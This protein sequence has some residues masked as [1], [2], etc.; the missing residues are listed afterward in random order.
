MAKWLN[1]GMAEWRNG[2]MADCH[3]QWPELFKSNRSS[4]TTGPRFVETQAMTTLGGYVTGKRGQ[5]CVVPTTQQGY[6]LVQSPAPQEEKVAP[7]LKC[8]EWDA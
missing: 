3:G 8:G 5:V 6:S 1:G 4:L 7:W 2:G